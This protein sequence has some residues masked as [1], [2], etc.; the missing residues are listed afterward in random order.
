MACVALKLIAVNWLVDQK[1]VLLTSEPLEPQSQTVF[2]TYHET[3]KNF[4]NKGLSPLT[5]SAFPLGLFPFSSLKIFTLKGDY[6]KKFSTSFPKLR[7]VVVVEKSPCG[8]LL[9]TWNHK[10][11][12]FDIMIN[13]NLSQ[14]R[15]TKEVIQCK[16]NYIIQNNYFQVH[17]SCLGVSYL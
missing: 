13:F 14:G 16:D 10:R 4:S 5:V 2:S 6:Y 15:T 8:S 3:G 12:K 9:F 1:S 17:R 7:G 11:K